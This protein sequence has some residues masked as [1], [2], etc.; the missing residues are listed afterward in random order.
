V[1]FTL[2]PR[3][4]FRYWAVCLLVLASLLSVASANAEANAQAKEKGQMI[5]A[6]DFDHALAE[7]GP[8]TYQIFKHTY[9][10]VGLSQAYKYSGWRSL[11]IQDVAG[12]GGFPELQGYFNT[13]TSGKLHFHFAFMVVEINERF[14][15]ALAGKSH[16]RLRKHGIGFWLENKAGRLRHYV[17]GEPIELFPLDPFV[18]YQLDLVYDVDQG[19]YALTI[20]NEFGQRLVELEASANAVNMPGSTLNMFSFIGD[21]EDQQNASYYV[22][23]VILYSQQSSAPPDFVAPGRRKLFVDI[24]NDYHQALYGKI[25][26]LPAVQSMD[27]GV[28]FDVF[29]D[30]M[31][32]HHY[33][34]LTKLLANQQVEP[35]DWQS[36]PYLQAIDLWRKGCSNLSGKNWQQ[37]I[38][39]FDEANQLISSARMYRL[40]L[41]LAYAGAGD[42]ARSDALLASIQSEWVNEPRLSVAYAM[43]GISRDDLDSATQWLTQ[44]ALGAWEDGMPELFEGLYS[45]SINANVIAQLQL[46]DPDNWPELLEQAVIT[47][48]YYFAQLWQK[49]YYEAY[50]YARTMTTRLQELGFVSAKW[51]ERTADAAF[52]NQDYEEAIVY[53][54]AALTNDNACYC[55]YLKLAD[56]FHIKGD[57]TRER[58]YREMIYGKF[59]NVD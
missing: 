38:A 37:A 33:D 45:D 2:A 21:L 41:A 7:V 36:N 52:Y 16:F 39:E 13:I 43:V 51:Q 59:E 26:C 11:K 15:I 29:T 54:E 24:W 56:V 40:S 32:T 34:T 20:E 46:F 22:D 55:N 48:Q 8:D 44:S 53:Y 19:Q 17:D 57:S 50:L 28:D 27:L 6:Y 30:L 35:G 12:D 31:A 49:N 10:K 25:Q 1:N 4:Y 58:E 47:E 23:D 9:G 14:N 5:V 3:T 18:W 42:Y